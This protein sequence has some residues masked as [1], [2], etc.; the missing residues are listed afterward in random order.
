MAP[1][2]SLALALLPIVFSCGGDDPPPHLVGVADASIDAPEPCKGQDMYTPTFGS[3]NQ[4]ADEYPAMGSGADATLHQIYFT[5]GLD[6]NT[7]GDYLFIDL[8]QDYG[9]FTGSDIGSGTFTISGEDAT[10]STCGV[11]VTIAAQADTT[12]VDDWYMATGGI[13]TLTS[14]SGQLTGSV[15]NLSFRRVATDVNGGPGDTPLDGPSGACNAHITSASFDVPL[16]LGSAA[17][18]APSARLVGTLP[19]VLRHRM[20]K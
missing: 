16:M 13:V 3:D 5:G 12:M 14:V 10:Y 4:S 7:P 19:R 11:C 2:F 15:Q 9:A 17:A 20:V 6:T 1:K 18:G 8:Y